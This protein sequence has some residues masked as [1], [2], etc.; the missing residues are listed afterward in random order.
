MTTPKHA[1]TTPKFQRRRID[2]RPSYLWILISF[3]AISI[4]LQFDSPTIGTAHA[5]LNKLLGDG[6]SVLNLV[7]VALGV[8]ALVCL[9]GAASG[10]P[11]FR[12]EADLRDCYH[13]QTWALIPTSIAAAVFDYGLWITAEDLQIAVLVLAII[14]GLLSNA[15]DFDIEARRLTEELVRRVSQKEA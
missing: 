13:I 8:G 12:H 11:R 5:G 10:T 9:F 2:H 6:N 7:G 15:R 1:P 3:V 14:L 4:M